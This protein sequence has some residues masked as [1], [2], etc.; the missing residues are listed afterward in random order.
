MSIRVVESGK[1]QLQRVKS[2]LGQGRGAEEVGSY[3]T[4]QAV[5]P[6]TV[7]IIVACI[8][9]IRHCWS[10]CGRSLS[11]PI[12]YHLR[13]LLPLPLPV[14]SLSPDRSARGA[15]QSD[16]CEWQVV[17]SIT[18]RDEVIVHHPQHL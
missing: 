10:H 14:L 4:C 5:S 1:W 2:R 15:H 13:W 8:S 16:L 18:T 6:S 9:R 12:E 11:H 7:D 3:R 17:N